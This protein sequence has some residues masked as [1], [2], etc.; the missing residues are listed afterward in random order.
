MLLYLVTILV[1][2]LE[3][4]CAISQG[5]MPFWF[6]THVL[7]QRWGLVFAV[8]A[9]VIGLM[10]VGGDA[11]HFVGVHGKYVIFE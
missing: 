7:L 1:H 8:I 4:V 11:P 5:K 6:G 9:A 10:I 3:A 2:S